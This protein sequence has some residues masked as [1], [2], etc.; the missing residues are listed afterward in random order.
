MKILCPFCLEKFSNSKAKLICNNSTH[1]CKMQAT[2]AFADYWEMSMDDPSALRPHIYDGG[3][4]LFGA[5]KRKK[6][7][8]CGDDNA[9]YVCPHCHNALP[10]DMVQFGTDIIPIIGGPG[11]GKT[12]YMVTLIDQ[13]NK[14]G[15]RLNL[16]ASLQSLYGD[17]GD[18]YKEMHTQLFKDKQVLGKT[19]SRNESCNIPWFIKVENKV[20]SKKIKPTYLIFYDMAGEQFENAKIMDKQA[21]PIQFA[22]GAIVL[23]DMFDI[24]TIKKVRREAGLVNSDTPFSIQDTVNELFGLSSAKR[25]LQ[26]SPIAF[27]FSKVDVVDKFRASLGQFGQTIDMRQNS[28]Y[29]RPEYSRPGSFTEKDFKMFLLECEQIKNDFYTALAEC[30]M[31]ALMNNNK[32]EDENMGY[33]GVSALGQEPEYDGSINCE[34]IRPFRVLDPLI[35]ILYKL[36]KIDIPK[37]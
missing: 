13:L 11:V 15:W 5:A 35:W 4:N 21:R 28:I 24:P 37:K 29:T 25:V 26:N 1:K 9:E 30:E 23:L 27:A 12:C 18:S 20:N 17:S 7:P 8:V 16:T 22:S 32:W 33:F 10:R 31:E 3:F 19:A 34:T 2:K 14:Y 36:G 6:C